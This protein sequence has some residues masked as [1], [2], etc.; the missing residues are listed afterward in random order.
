MIV[1]QPQGTEEH[2]WVQP[3]DKYWAVRDILEA[4]PGRPVG[5]LWKPLPVRFLTSDRGERLLHSDLPWYGS[6]VMAVTRRARDVLEPVVA[7][8]RSSC[9]WTARRK[10]SG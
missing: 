9:R 4:E 6:D 2:Q 1:Y 7:G 3:V 10:S 5:S 8:M